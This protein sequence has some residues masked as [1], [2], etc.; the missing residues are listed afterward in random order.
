M[1]MESFAQLQARLPERI[2]EHAVK[3]MLPKNSLGR[4]LFTKLKVYAGT[5]HLTKPKTSRVKNSDN[6]RRT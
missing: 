2:V 4:Q 6:S 1:K 3:G 5:D